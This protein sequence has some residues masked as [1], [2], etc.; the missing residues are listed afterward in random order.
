MWS[1][2]VG[3]TPPPP[4]RDDG[5]AGCG[6]GAEFIRAA[7]AG[8]GLSCCSRCLWD[9]DGEKRA[10]AEL[11]AIDCWDVRGDGSDGASEGVLREPESTAG[12]PLRRLSELFRSVARR[13]SGWW[14]LAAL[15]RP[16]E[17]DPVVR[18]AAA[19]SPAG[20]DMP[21]IET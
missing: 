16:P 19:A 7:A 6:E 21:N 10:T 11:R 15:L 2:S 12:L 17:A 20:P 4:K 1:R 8:E 13:P 5:E 14:P 3:L 9:P 18:A